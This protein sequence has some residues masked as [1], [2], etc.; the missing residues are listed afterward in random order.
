[1]TPWRKNRHRPHSPYLHQWLNS[2]L[3]NN[4]KG[5][6]KQRP[7]AQFTSR[8]FQKICEESGVKQLTTS[9][10]PHANEQVERS[11]AAIISMLLYY[12]ADQQQDWDSHV[13]SL[14][15]AYN[16][17]VHRQQN[18]VCSQQPRG[19]T[20]LTA[21]LMPPDVEH[22]D[23][24]LEL[25]ICLM[26]RAPELIQMAERNLHKAEGRYKGDR[27]R[28]VMFEPTVALGEYVFVERP[29]LTTKNSRRRATS[30]R[31]LRKT[32]LLSSRTQSTDK[33]RTTC[34][35]YYRRRN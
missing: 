24:A 15:Y 3:R 21:N 17:Q 27:D 11:N 32:S 23:C 18:L 19:P 13:V 16:T 28:K 2:E 31:E 6:D 7:A 8:F 1:M 22:V 5:L 30:R 26:H 4:V 34:R 33:R 10:Y 35:P 14:N 12:D 9:E 20:T 25:Q 29:P